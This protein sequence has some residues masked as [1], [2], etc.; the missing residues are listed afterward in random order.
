M[1]KRNINVKTFLSSMKILTTSEIVPKAESKFLFWFPF[2]LLVDFSSVCPYWMQEKPLK[3]T[4]LRRLS[5]QLFRTKGWYQKAGTSS[6][7]RVSVRIFKMTKCCHRNYGKNFKFNFIHNKALQ[8]FKP[9]ALIQKIL[10][11]F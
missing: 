5:K 10:I 3:W 9:L 2:L 11:W 7:K 4:F 8:T 6:H 1:V